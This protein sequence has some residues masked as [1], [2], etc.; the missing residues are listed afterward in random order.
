MSSTLTASGAAAL[1]ALFAAAAIREHSHVWPAVRQWVLSALAPVHR[2]RSEGYEPSDSERRRLWM[3]CSGALAVV[4][5]VGIG[6]GPYL[7]A[8]AAVPLASDR[9]IA[10]RRRRYRTAFEADLGSWARSIGDQL[11]AGASARSAVLTGDEIPGLSAELGRV[12]GEVEAGMAVGEAL[13]RLAGRLDSAALDSIVAAIELADRTGG[14]VRPLLARFADANDQRLEVMADARSATAQARM[15]G[16]MVAA[17]P[18]AG[19]V[20]AEAGRPGFFAVILADSIASTLI[21][22]STA[23]QLVAFIAIRR[24]AAVA[25]R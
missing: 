24:I 2:A 15:T 8:L 12:R 10:A 11:A 17:M 5:L 21:A 4:L 22:L 6:P 1:A 20:L 18:A 13:A 7:V 3:V 19:L 9:V 23:M 25:E 14:E 16:A